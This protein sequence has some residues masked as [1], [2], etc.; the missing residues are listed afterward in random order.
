MSNRPFR[1]IPIVLV[2]GVTA[3]GSAFAGPPYVT[4][5]TET[6]PRTNWEIN[7]AYVQQRTGDPRTAQ[8]PIFDFNYGLRDAYSAQVRDARDVREH[9][10]SFR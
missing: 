7:I 3:S 4:D 9:K 1:V 2:L 6:P 5:D 10:R 8:T